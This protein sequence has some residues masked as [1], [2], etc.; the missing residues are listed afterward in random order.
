MQ[1]YIQVYI[2]LGNLVQ[3]VR[4]SNDD[5]GSPP[6][7][8]DDINIP[9]ALRKSLRG[10]DFVLV[11]E[12]KGVYRMLMFGTASNLEM[13]RKA[14]DWFLDGTFSVCPSLF[15]Q[16]YT[17]N[18]IKQGNCF[19]IN[20]IKIKLY[21]INCNYFLGQ[22]LPMLYILLTKKDE[23]TYNKAF[24]KIRS[25]V[26]CEPKSLNVDFEKSALNSLFLNFPSSQLAGCY[27]HLT[28]NLFRQVQKCKLVKEYNNKEFYKAFGF[29]KCLAFVPM[30]D[31][32][33]AFKFIQS[34]APSSFKPILDYFETYYIGR[35]NPR[36]KEERAVPP[37]PISLWNLHDRVLKDKA[38]CNNSLE[39]WHKAFEVSN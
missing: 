27:F 5:Y 38:R 1:L 24:E 25:L 4:S 26:G 14:D 34:I 2:Q 20:K 16:L 22:N 21:E 3:N 39:A 23:L 19:K 13:M 33:K 8:L 12:G 29:L 37:F 31:V 9:I 17:F 7:D 36:N 28:Q 30:V 15:Y 10:E 18:I 35:E 32:I 6:K 11:D